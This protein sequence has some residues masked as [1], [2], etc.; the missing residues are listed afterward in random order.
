MA[1]VAHPSPVLLLLGTHK[2]FSLC[3][4]CALPVVA[5]QE[6]PGEGASELPDWNNAF[7]DFR[8]YLTEK[9]LGMSYKAYLEQQYA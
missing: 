7:F 9:R 3:C 1:S 4:S 8:T 5:G 6:V 2:L